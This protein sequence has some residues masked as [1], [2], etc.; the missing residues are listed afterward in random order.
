MKLAQLHL[1]EAS[2]TE[3]D[4]EEIYTEPTA[5]DVADMMAGWAEIEDGWFNVDYVEQFEDAL[6]YGDGDLPW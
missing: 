4:V 6:L 5:Q 2:F 3:Q 1:L